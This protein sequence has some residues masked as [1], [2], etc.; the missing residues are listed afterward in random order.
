MNTFSANEVVTQV[1]GLNTI[2]TLNRWRKIVEEHFGIKYFQRCFIND[3][4]SI[5][6]YSLDDVKH[7]QLVSLILSGQP[8]NRKNLRQAI[9]TA[10]SSDK[11]L[12]KKKTEIEVLEDTFNRRI[13]DL[14]NESKRLLTDIQE[15]NR[16]LVIIENQFT[17]EKEGR[18]KLFRRK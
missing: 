13:A 11:P 12:V 5:I 17:S 1:D 10:F 4:P 6:S 3:N 8:S 7:F 2:K 16:K 18:P 9:I 15:I 14:E